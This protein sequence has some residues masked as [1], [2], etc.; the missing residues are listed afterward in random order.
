[1]RRELGQGPFLYRYSGMRE[2]EGAF[3]AASFRVAGALTALGRRDEATEALDALTAA[4]TNDVGLLSEQVEPG[5][6][7]F[8]GNLPQGLSHPALINAVTDLA[9]TGSQGRS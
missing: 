1:M 7:A 9:D 6:G 3:V 4:A 8:L 5:T 2:G